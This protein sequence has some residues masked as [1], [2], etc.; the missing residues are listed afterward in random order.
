MTRWGGDR[1][2]STYPHATFNSLVVTCSDVVSAY[3]CI[4]ASMP[5]VFIELWAV[6]AIVYFL[7]CPIA[8]LQHI[9]G[10]SWLTFSSG[11]ITEIVPQIQY[12]S[13]LLV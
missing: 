10:S 5:D 4:S 8:L 7:K 1:L 3:K 13:S 11:G 9:R 12:L 2:L 6:K